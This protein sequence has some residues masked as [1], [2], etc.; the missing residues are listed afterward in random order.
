MRILMLRDGVRAGT[1]TTVLRYVSVFLIAY[2]LLYFFLLL[3]LLFEGDL[4]H[5]I[6]LERRHFDPYEE[7]P[8]D[9]NSVLYSNAG[10]RGTQRT[11]SAVCDGSE[12]QITRTTIDLRIE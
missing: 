5:V 2:L 8:V 12:P 11:V 10:D 4:L 1:D 3:L 6:A 7:L 9:A